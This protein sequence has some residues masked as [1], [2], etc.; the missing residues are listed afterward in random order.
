[1]TNP[2]YTPEFLADRLQEVLDQAGDVSGLLDAMTRHHGRELA[3]AAY[4]VLC[5]RLPGIQKPQYK[6]FDRQVGEWKNGV[7]VFYCTI[8][9][10]PWSPAARGGYVL[11]G[12]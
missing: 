8:G 12:V 3:E 7:Y 6:R 9:A 2:T 5:S 10:W 4:A 11:T 1:M